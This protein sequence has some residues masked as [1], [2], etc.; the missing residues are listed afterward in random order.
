[1]IYNL[2]KNAHILASC[3]VPFP[4]QGLQAGPLE[5]GDTQACL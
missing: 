1:M 4:L 2:D 3:L 5:P